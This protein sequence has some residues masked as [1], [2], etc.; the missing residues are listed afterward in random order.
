VLVNSPNCLIKKVFEMGQ[1]VV[2]KMASRY[3]RSRKK[4]KE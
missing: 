4:E 2:A 3:E 1:A